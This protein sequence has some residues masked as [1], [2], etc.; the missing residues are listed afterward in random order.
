[1]VQGS[2]ASSFTLKKQRAGRTFR[3]KEADG[4]GS[5]HPPGW[6]DYSQ[7]QPHQDLALQRG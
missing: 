1:M 6:F 5:I 7:E 2:E 4:S 3:N